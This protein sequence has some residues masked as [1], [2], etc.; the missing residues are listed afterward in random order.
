MFSVF[1]KYNHGPCNI[2]LTDNAAYHHP[3]RVLHECE[4]KQSYKYINNT[5]K[6][7]RELDPD[8]LDAALRQ[9]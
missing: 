8:T 2:I 4:P 1:I 9:G 3:L 7:H 5:A 6:E